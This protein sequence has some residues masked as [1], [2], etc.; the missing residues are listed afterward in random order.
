[1][2]S[3]QKHFGSGSGITSYMLTSAVP[4]G[5]AEPDWFFLPV[6]GA[7]WDGS[8]GVQLLA[9]WDGHGMI[10][11]QSHAFTFTDFPAPRFAWPGRC[12]VGRVGPDAPLPG[13]GWRRVRAPRAVRVLGPGRARAWLPP[14]ALGAGVRPPAGYLVG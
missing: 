10:A 8:T 6:R 14:P 12:R 7:P 2:L 1:R 4:A 13:A 9:E 5:E 3:G 11:T